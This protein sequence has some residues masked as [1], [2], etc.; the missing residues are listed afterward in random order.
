MTKRTVNRARKDRQ[1][2]AHAIAAKRII[3]RHLNE[4]M[5]EQQKT[6]QALAQE[7]QTSRSQL[8][9]LLDPENIAV[10]LET[11]ARAVGVLGKRV[12]FLV[13]DLDCTLGLDS[14]ASK[15][16]VTSVSAQIAAPSEIEEAAS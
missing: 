13:E 11:I 12:V 1:S 5:I 2:R 4:A 6:K 10:S 8:A 3:V 16:S 7:L 9:R 14:R 15:K